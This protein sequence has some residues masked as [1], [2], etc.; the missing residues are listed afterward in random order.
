MKTAYHL[1]ESA[2][3]SRAAAVAGGVRTR[4]QGKNRART[5]GCDDM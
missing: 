1:I 2:Y 5:R 3:Q 4:L